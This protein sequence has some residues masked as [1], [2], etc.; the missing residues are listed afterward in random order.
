MY[1]LADPL[2]LIIRPIYELINNYAYTLIIVTILIRILTIPFTVMSQKNVAKTQLI[3]PELAAIQKKY[4]ND[5]DKLAMEMQ[6]LYTK[7]GVNPLGGCLPLIVQMFIL[8]GFIGVIY[9]PL[10][11]ILQ[12]SK[13]VIAQIAAAVN[14]AKNT[15]DVYLC[16]IEGVSQK[17]KDLGHTPINFDF[18]GMNLAQMPKG[19]TDLKV[20]IFPVLAVLSTIA[21][22]Y[23]TK[24]QT[25]SQMNGSGNEQ[26]QSM[27]DTMLKIMPVMTAV[28]TYMMPVAM[29]LY[30]FVSTVLQ[31]IQQTVINN[32]INEKVKKEISAERKGK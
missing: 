6:K 9:N 18:F 24:I 20:W 32:V 29:S 16:G 13:D 23:I 30:W 26:A 2:A 14:Q 3:Q 4:A 17:I 11:Y 15:Q 22:S 27:S 28:F 21:S 12:L 1:I 19:S 5:R 25:K 31:I 10:Q 7:H 8:F